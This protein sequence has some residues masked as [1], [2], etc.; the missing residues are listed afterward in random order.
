MNLQLD[1]GEDIGPMGIPDGFLTPPASAAGAVPP[2]VITDENGLATVE[3][4]YLIMYAGWIMDRLTASTSAL[5][6]ENQTSREWYLSATAA[7]I[8]QCNGV[9]DS[10]FGYAVDCPAF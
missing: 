1:A 5:M 6:T 10:P 2:F 3:I 8:D 4:A 9:F 7:D